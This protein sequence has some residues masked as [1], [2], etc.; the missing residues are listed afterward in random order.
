MAGVPPP[1]GTGYWGVVVLTKNTVAFTTTPR[2]DG[3]R[4]PS[5]PDSYSNAAT[6]ARITNVATSAAPSNTDASPSPVIC[7]TINAVPNSAPM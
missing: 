2:S 4:C 3:R 7:Q 5:Q 1:A 6:V